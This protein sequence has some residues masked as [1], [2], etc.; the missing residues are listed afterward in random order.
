MSMKPVSTHLIEVGNVHDAIG[1]R[2]E[3]RPDK[4]SRWENRL[5]ATWG[6]GNRGE[7]AINLGICKGC[8]C[9]IDTTPTPLRFGDETVEFPSTVCEECM[10]LVREHYD[11]KRIEE[12]EATAT[13]KWD[14][15]CPDRHKQVALGEV[16]PAQIDWAAFERVAGW[17]PTNGRGLI[18]TGAPGTGKTSAL[19]LLARNLELAGISPITIGSVELGRVLSEA[20]RDIREVGWLYRCRVLL[21]DDLGKEKASPAMSALLWEVFDRRLSS[22]LPVIVTTN[23]TGEMFAARFG[24]KH[25]GDAIRRRISEL[26]R[27]VHFNTQQQQKA[28]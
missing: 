14:A 18:L 10:A 16:R 5:A 28:A 12:A 23:F 17:E 2:I 4:R 11:P 8:A 25:L 24:E 6:N 9:E 13:P 22:N 27:H 20:A 15:N 26:C 21:I 19:W 1:L 7:W 3:I